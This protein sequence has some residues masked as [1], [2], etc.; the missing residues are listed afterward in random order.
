[1]SLQ[2]YTRLTIN[3]C[4][5]MDKAQSVDM[6]P[7]KAGSAAPAL[8]NGVLKHEATP[9]AMEVDNPQAFAKGGGE[10]APLPKWRWRLLSFTLLPGR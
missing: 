6:P 1:M 4:A 3:P 8:P 10:Q 2:P 9:E 7:V 5:Q